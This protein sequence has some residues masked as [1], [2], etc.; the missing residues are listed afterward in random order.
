[1]QASEVRVQGQNP[2]LPRPSSFHYP[3]ED[4]GV[5]EAV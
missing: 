1:M 4:S 3:Q 5:R 2:N